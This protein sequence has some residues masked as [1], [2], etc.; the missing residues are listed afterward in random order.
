MP[1]RI[2]FPGANTLLG[3]VNRTGRSPGGRRAVSCAAC[4]Y[5]SPAILERDHRLYQAVLCFDEVESAGNAE[6]GDELLGP[7]RSLLPSA[8]SLPITARSCHHEMVNVQGRADTVR[9]GLGFVIPI[10]RGRL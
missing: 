8:S 4:R 3:L 2:A 10:T 9:H 7:H 6:F 1:P 5:R